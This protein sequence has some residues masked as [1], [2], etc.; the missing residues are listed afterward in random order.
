MCEYRLRPTQRL[1]LLEPV[2]LRIAAGLFLCL[3]LHGSLFAQTVTAEGVAPMSAGN[4]SAAREVAIRNALAEVARQ[5]SAHVHSVTSVRASALGFDQ[6]VVS[7][8]AR[9]R[10]HEVIDEHR[11]GDIYRVLIRVELAGAVD[12][13]ATSPGCRQGYA[14][15]LLIGG[16]PLEHPEHLLSG[17]LSGYAR[18][19]AGEIAKRMGSA[20]A[21]LV[22]YQGDLMVHPG[23][24][25][26]VR[27]STTTEEQAWSKVRSAAEQHRAQYLL[28]GEFRSFELDRWHSQRQLDLEVALVDPFTGS[29]VARSRFTETAYGNVVV[30]R[31]A[32]F[33]GAE[34]LATGLGK[35]YNK[36]LQRVAE[37]AEAKASCQPFG[38]R[39]IQVSG[40]Q[41]YIDV[42]AEQGVSIDDTFSIFKVKPAVRSPFSG[43][44][45]GVEKEARGEAR[46]V[47]IYPRFAVAEMVSGSV[48]GLSVGDEAYSR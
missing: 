33:G 20:P 45:L 19:T 13:A 44:L 36:L 10:R 42:G 24:P 28:V 48:A 22:D 12:D 3:L 5:S 31:G 47:S 39:I 43:E 6:T 30:P 38:A 2:S 41:L 14:K 7:A 17:E 27:S 11:D 29:C 26:R 46:V 1:L 18:L 37:W 21:V 8:S 35:A 34:H 4:P 23:R 16:F 15:R 25:E 32:R 40:N 9:I